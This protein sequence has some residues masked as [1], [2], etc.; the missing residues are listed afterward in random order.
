[1]GNTHAT[2]HAATEDFEHAFSATDRVE[3]LHEDTEA[4]EGVTGLLLTI[5]TIGVL[6]FALVVCVITFQII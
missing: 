6:F 3:L 4:W 1:M 2:E 5:V